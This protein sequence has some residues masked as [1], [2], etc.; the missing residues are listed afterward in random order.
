MSKLHLALALLASAASLAPPAAAQ[1]AAPQNGR[2]L[3]AN[4]QA[5]SGGVNPQNTQLDYS[6]RNLLITGQVTG[7]RQFRG[8]AGIRAEGAFGGELGSDDLFRFRADS[9]IPGGVGG[10]P[11]QRF[12]PQPGSG[13]IA[14]GNIIYDSYFTPSA[15]RTGSGPERL[16]VG[17]DG[18]SAARVGAGATRF[19]PDLLRGPSGG[20]VAA[21]GGREGARAGGDTL[22]RFE[23]PDGRR[24]QLDASPLFG[25]RES[26]VGPPAGEAARAAA[27]GEAT[28][29]GQDA[30]N[31][32]DLRRTTASAPSAATPG[33]REL[34][35]GA[36]EAP[37]ADGPRA[38]AV[39]G[40]NGGLPAGAAG[41]AAPTLPREAQRR[42]P[43]A[44]DPEA[45][46][47][48]ENLG[49]VARGGVPLAIQLGAQ[50]NPVLR[51]AG[52]SGEQAAAGGSGDRLAR[53]RAQILRPLAEEEAGRGD[54]DTPEPYLDLLRRLR[55]GELVTD[56]GGPGADRPAWMRE[57]AG[58]S[59]E[60]LTNAENRRQ[61]SVDDLLRGLGAG[62]DDAA[63]AAEGDAASEDARAVAS[64]LGYDGPRLET[65][66][67]ARQNR[68]NESLAGAEAAL[69]EGRFFDAE[70]LY[71]QVVLDAGEQPLARVGLVHAQMAAGMIRSAA[72]SLRELYNDHPELI[73]ARYAE[74]LLPPADRM[75]WLRD[76]LQ[77][78]I[79]DPQ[80]PKA[81]PALMLAYLG[82]Q[83]ESRQL[84][85]Y[86][87]ALAEE[88][89][90]AD[91]LFSL[92]RA[93]WLA[94][95]EQENP[96]AP[97][98]AAEPQPDPQ[99]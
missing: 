92:L 83:V 59:D 89:R 32:Q 13:G 20:R 56:A 43:G 17:A 42:L 45:S 91:P 51:N 86:G 24:L 96:P 79:D 10:P 62:N 39:Q 67:G 34:R 14:G 22:G 46:G 2:A 36:G 44:P 19:N 38:A 52:G 74:K 26:E 9:A 82:R 8:D 80:S 30:P 11:T 75:A 99:K 69:A 61:R 33:A 47:E 55:G 35:I 3:D 40:R 16:V 66:R 94:R 97:A 58:V 49:G 57:L 1:R 60:A 7:G 93:A 29:D 21:D 72:L 71:R 73:S 81:E 18:V 64:Q 12:T 78:L 31:P 53:L 77:K 28:G 48:G 50:L 15:G 54:G 65:L 41:E 76:E 27:G 95:P 23:A 70:S 4:P 6:A 88:A 37:A 68:I 84:V 5:G 63:G 98:Q 25:V 87:L 85:R 90:P